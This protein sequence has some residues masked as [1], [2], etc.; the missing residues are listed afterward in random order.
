MA[1]KSVS[2]PGYAVQKTSSPVTTSSSYSSAQVA[3]SALI[4]NVP[5]AANGLCL[6][7]W[8]LRADQ[9]GFSITNGGSEPGGVSQEEKQT[10]QFKVASG[11]EGGWYGMYTLISFSS[12][13]LPPSA[14]L[15]DLV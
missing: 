5:S 8:T 14:F 4:V 15:G 2:E 3:S 9:A 1:L 6:V 13:P 10:L 7:E 12:F 11:E